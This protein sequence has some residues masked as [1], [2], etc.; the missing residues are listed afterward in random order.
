MDKDQSRIGQIGRAQDR[1]APEEAAV[2]QSAD[3]KKLHYNKPQLLV[4]LIMAQII[5]CIWGRRTGKTEGPMADF[6]LNNIFSMPRSNGFLSG[7]TYEQLLTRTLPPLIAA[8]ERRGYYENVHFWVRKFPPADLKVPKAYRSPLKP[9]HYIQWYNGSGIYL[10][11]QDRPGTIN[12][13]ATQWG[14]ADEAKFQN[15]D[16]LREEALLCRAL[17]P[18]ELLPERDVLLRHAEHQQRHLAAR[19]RRPDG[20]RGG[21]AHPAG[22]ANSPRPAARVGD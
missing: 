17:R 20:Q 6:T 10:V 2:L 15:Y 21:A 12:G 7:T 3:V 14:A 4:H 9:D 19:L 11:S 13:V 22:A 16:K 8:W 18:P 5:V 1:N